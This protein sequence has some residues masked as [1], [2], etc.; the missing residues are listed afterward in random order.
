MKIFLNHGRKFNFKMKELMMELDTWFRIGNAWRGKKAQEGI[1]QS[2]WI[3]R[4]A[5]LNVGLY[6]CWPTFPVGLPRRTWLC[7]QGCISPSGHFKQ[8]RPF[9]NK[10][11]CFAG[12]LSFSIIQGH[13][14]IHNL[15]SVAL[16]V[17][18]HCLKWL[19]QNAYKVS[20]IQSEMKIVVVV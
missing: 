8:K 3:L 18:S 4:T 17:K 5:F 6:L 2:L 9:L 20:K 16:A 12:V 15:T 19:N 14:C 10:A 13:T 1:Y 11:I 7:F